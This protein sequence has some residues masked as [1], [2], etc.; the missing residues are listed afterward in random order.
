MKLSFLAAVF[1]LG[2]TIVATPISVTVPTGD[3]P[4][5]FMSI[6]EA[7][8]EEWVAPGF[9]REFLTVIVTDVEPAA[10][11]TKIAEVLGAE[12][13]MEGEKWVLFRSSA[14]LRELRDQDIA[15][16]APTLQEQLNKLKPLTEQLDT[17]DL[18]ALV[19][20]DLA[21]QMN[22][23]DTNQ[24]D[25][26]AIQSLRD[27]T[28]GQRVIANMLAQINAADLVSMPPSGRYIYT[29]QGGPRQR[30]LPPVCASI[31]QRGQRDEAWLKR[32]RSPLATNESIDFGFFNQ[33]PVG[34]EPW[35]I[36]VENSGFGGLECSFNTFAKMSDEMYYV[37]NKASWMFNPL[38]N[39]PPVA[40]S[41]D[42]PG[43]DIELS[44][45]ENERKFLDIVRRRVVPGNDPT[46]E[47]ENIFHWLAAE[48]PY[49]FVW[50]SA[51]RDLA[52][53]RELNVV[54]VPDVMAWYLLIFL[55]S[56]TPT[57]TIAS[58]A[59]ATINSP[60][61]RSQF[62]DGW[63][64]IQPIRS[65]ALASPEPEREAVRRLFTILA[66]DEEP[67]GMD[68]ARFVADSK[69]EDYMNVGVL[70][71]TF[72]QINSPVMMVFNRPS[73][74]KGYRIVGSLSD[75]QLA[76]LRDGRPIFVSQLSSRLRTLMDD[77][78]YCDSVS[79]LRSSNSRPQDM[80][81]YD[82]TNP[83]EP[84]FLFPNGLPND[85]TLSRSAW[86]TIQALVTLRA[87]SGTITQQV[88]SASTLA[89][90]IVNQQPNRNIVLSM[91]PVTL[92]NEK[93]S[94]NAGFCERGVTLI[95]QQ[96][97]H[98]REPRALSAMPEEFRKQVEEIMVQY[99]R[100]NVGNPPPPTGNRRP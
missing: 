88:M 55:I 81:M 17:E 47:R 11:R 83:G 21:L 64:M 9:N 25:W 98:G 63:L 15:R 4:T 94:L 49:S 74:W 90:S 58:V 77:W 67:T 65:A 66:S 99:Q 52:K 97:P 3:V 19:A 86:D 59:A 95:G 38:P 22:R 27:Q 96:F 73:S 89:W 43:A 48:E 7:S 36:R 42:D 37:Q 50:D 69:A 24:Y 16:L 87:P 33:L 18:Q 92:Q 5:V 51:L 39:A 6:N 56:Q 28:P 8:G 10:L 71:I 85:A 29:L 76:V 84:T 31:L 35:F 54:A 60:Y 32:N 23:T 93:F 80:S 70:P 75:A 34:D 13:R 30:R 68:I 100:N 45:T 40:P 78:F 14:K 62:A 2:S 57:A 46:T 26:R 41:A 79:Q 1:L 44:L 82:M 53:H 20:G 61:S 12:W 72:S 91:V